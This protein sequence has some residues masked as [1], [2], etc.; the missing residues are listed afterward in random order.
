MKLVVFSSKLNI[1]FDLK[2]QHLSRIISHLV[3]VRV[4]EYSI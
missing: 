3:K 4:E 1:V 2:K